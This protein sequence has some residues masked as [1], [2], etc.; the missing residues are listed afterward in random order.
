MYITIET[1]YKQVIE[2]NFP[3]TYQAYLNEIK[4]TH[5]IRNKQHIGLHNIMPE[6]QDNSK[7]NVGQNKECHKVLRTL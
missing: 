2:L 1:F 5:V 6:E 7:Y 4:C 3:L